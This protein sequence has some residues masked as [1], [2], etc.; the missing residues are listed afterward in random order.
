MLDKLGVYLE[1]MEVV[2]G[3]QERRCEYL[4]ITDKLMNVKLKDMPTYF[5]MEKA[6]FHITYGR[7]WS[8]NVSTAIIASGAAGDVTIGKYTIFSI[9]RT[10]CWGRP[11]F[12]LEELKKMDIDLQDDVIWMNA[13]DLARD[14][15]LRIFSP[16]ELDYIINTIR[17]FNDQS[18]IYEFVS[19]HDIFK[20]YEDIPAANYKEEFIENYDGVKCKVLDVDALD[21]TK[22]LTGRKK[23]ETVVLKANGG[24]EVVATNAMGM[25]ESKYV[26]S[27]G[28]AI[29]FN[30]E[31]DIYVPRDKQG[32]TWN[33]DEVEKHGYDLVSGTFRVGE[34][35]AIRV[36][37][38]K[39]AKLLKEII[40]IPTCIKNAWG[41][42]SHQFLSEGA[43]LKRDLE[44]GAITGISKDSFDRTWEIVP[45]ENKMIK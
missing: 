30:N 12:K 19:E 20:D 18:L 15:L 45:N 42:G 6:I 29:F 36:I 26:T 24:E 22:G 31:S 5:D 10:F 1:A 33:F 35:D 41:E 13:N 27:P 7:H 44:T 16:Q 14:R 2:F 39:Y 43:T 21:F 8:T 38:N 4:P 11:A 32:K 37:S 9:L 34:N 28:D 17:S 25:T 23:T 3:D 40:L